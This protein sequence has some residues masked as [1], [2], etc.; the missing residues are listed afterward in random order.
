VELF[1]INRRN[2][3]KSLSAIYIG[4]LL[5]GHGYDLIRSLDGYKVGLIGSGWY[6]KSDVFRLLQVADVEVIAISDVDANVVKK[7]AALISQR[8]KSGKKPVTYKDY[9][10]ML[11][12][13]Q[14]DL[15][16]IGTPDHWHAL[17]AID[18]M[19][20][21]AHVYLQKPV[22]TDVLEGE[23]I[24]SEARRLNRTVQIGTQRRS[25]PHLVEAK[26][27]IVD[28]GLLGKVAH[29]EIFCFYHMRFKG[30]PPVESVPDYFDYDMW[31]GPAPMRQFDGLPHRR[32]RAYMEYGNGIV[33]D[34][35]VHML[36][37][38]RWLLDLG[39]PKSVTSS[40]G[41]YMDKESNANIS[42]TQTAFFEYDELNIVWEHRSW[43]RPSDPEYPWAFKIYG[44]NGVLKGD[45]N[46]YEFEKNDGTVIGGKVVIEEDLFP[47]DV[48]E[49]GIEMR[50]APATR[51]HMVDW[52][53]A[54]ANGSKPVADIEQGFISSA[55]CIVANLAMK[56]GSSLSYNSELRVFNNNPQY[57]NLLKRVYR[58]DWEHPEKYL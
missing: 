36:D 55:S 20:A 14:L 37:A 9:R 18:A 47:E 35:C 3:L 24:L 51:A 32:W 17:N 1:N 27:K 29:V 46:Q 57:N 41:I 22:S 48:T 4:S 6:G 10:K 58:P 12:N 5:G 43:G 28:E 11:A 2:F 7:A 38:V 56:T 33:G 19:N 50:A 39:W 23:A 54:I 44:E 45:V 15:V 8:Q 31:C 40:G 42:D 21:G 52:L 16:L 53:A 26:K 13:H 49:K 34:M 30:N 25:T